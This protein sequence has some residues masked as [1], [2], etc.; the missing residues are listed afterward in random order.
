[1][2][3]KSIAAL[4]QEINMQAK[5]AQRI[6]QKKKQEEQ[7]VHGSVVDGCCSVLLKLI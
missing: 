4:T 5:E 1:M 6:K 3:A 7:K 2:L